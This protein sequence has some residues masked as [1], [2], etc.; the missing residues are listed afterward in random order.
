LIKGGSKI[1]RSEI[2]NLINSIWSKEELPED[3]KESVIA[4]IYM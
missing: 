4:P 3:W 1:I 2:H